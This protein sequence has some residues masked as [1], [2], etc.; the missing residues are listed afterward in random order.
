MGAVREATRLPVLAKD[1]FLTP[2]QVYEARA[3]GADAVLLIVAA[4]SDDELREFRQLAVELGLATLVEVHNAEELGRAVASGA[5]I[6]GINNRDLRTFEVDLAVT[7]ELSPQV[8]AG[9]VTVAESGIRTP[10]DVARLAAA[11]MDAVLVGEHLMRAVDVEKAT[12][13]LVSAGRRETG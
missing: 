4:L 5:D 1:F 8:P 3:Y 10:D 13:R 7:E 6:I 9:V 11:G 12:R 2:Y